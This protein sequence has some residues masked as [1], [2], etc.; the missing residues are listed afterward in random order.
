MMEQLPEDNTG[1]GDRPAGNPAKMPGT[2]LRE[3]RER[4][5]L[6]VA[7]VAN[8]IKF[9]PRQIEALEADDFKQLQG[10]TFLRGFVRSYAKILHL[11]AQPLLEQLPV[12]KPVP[13]QLTPAS[14]NMPFPSMLTS[15]QQ[16]LVWSV[17]A[18][19]IAVIVVAFG[20]WHTSPPSSLSEI[21]QAQP[22]VAPIETPAPLPAEVEIISEPPEQE[23]R[24]ESFVPVLPKE[25]SIQKTKSSP[26]MEQFSAPETAQSS[27][28][29][30][31]DK[32][33][34][35][36][37]A[38]KTKT[39]KPVSRKV[40]AVSDSSQPV[41]SL[42]LV[43]GEESWTE[44]KDKNGNVIS[45]QINQPGS[46][47]RVEGHPPFMMLIGHALSVHLYQDGEEVDLKPYIN[48]YSEVA[49]LTLE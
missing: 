4:L 2:T 42:R 33:Q 34:A 40:M 45:S 27:V 26:A 49:H 28:P 1:Q 3:A 23:T 16:N 41:S 6:S 7:D 25:K 9:A 31:R 8:Q 43:F 46:E 36:Q 35:A 17:A 12:D 11:D 24:I 22:E 30:T 29:L 21:T 20:L 13:Q 19:L 47:L 44:I 39:E 15:R 5:G 18:L 32:I 38:P 37:D 10:A 48:K 14:V